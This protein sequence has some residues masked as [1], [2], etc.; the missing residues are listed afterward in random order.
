VSR[1]VTRTGAAGRGFGFG[2]GFGFEA[3]PGHAQVHGQGHQPLLSTVVQVAFDAAAF[4]VGRSDQVGAAA[5][6]RLGPLGQLLPA[7][8]PEQ[9]LRQVLVDLNRPPG[10]PGTTGNSTASRAAPIP[11]GT[12]SRW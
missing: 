11:A 8:G 4:G 5:G 2:F 10:Q 7:G 1:S 9:P 6:Q 3:L 12:A